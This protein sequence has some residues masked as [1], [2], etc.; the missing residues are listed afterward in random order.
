MDIHRFRCSVR[1]KPASLLVVFG[2]KHSS[3]FFQ[4]FLIDCY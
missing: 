4:L 2:D 1:K 3:R